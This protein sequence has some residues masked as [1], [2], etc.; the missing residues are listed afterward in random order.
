MFMVLITLGRFSTLKSDTI[1]RCKLKKKQWMKIMNESCEL[2]C[3]RMREL[4]GATKRM[5]ELE[6]ATKRMNKL[7][8]AVKRMKSLEH[9]TKR[10]RKPEQK[11]EWQF[12]TTK[13]CHVGDRC[14]DHHDDLLLFD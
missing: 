3:T 4:G 14:F 10:T 9:A 6:C 2:E 8:H 13:L 11:K 1:T 7:E 5:K 12:N